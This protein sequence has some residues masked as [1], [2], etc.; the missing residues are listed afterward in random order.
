ME[1]DGDKC[2]N[3][4]EC[5]DGYW[6]TIINFTG[7][8]TADNVK[9]LFDSEDLLET[10]VAM[11]G[12]N[13]NPSVYADRYLGLLKLNLGVPKLELIIDRF[14]DLACTEPQFALDEG[15]ISG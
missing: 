7:N 12:L 8:T 4:F 15:H 11:E 3:D 9:F 2:W 10:G 14:R 13:S 5:N 1:D 6:S